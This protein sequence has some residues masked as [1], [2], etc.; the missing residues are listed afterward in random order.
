MLHLKHHLK[1]N[2][3]NHAIYKLFQNNHK[4]RLKINKYILKFMNR[5]TNSNEY[6]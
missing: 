4:N 5:M 6:S 1:K 2:L 3:K